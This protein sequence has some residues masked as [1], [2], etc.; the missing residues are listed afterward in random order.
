MSEIEKTH[1]FD[2]VIQI[3]GGYGKYQIISTFCMYFCC[4]VNGFIQFIAGRGL[5][6]GSFLKN[7]RGIATSPPKIV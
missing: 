4:M 7:F 1:I 3:V 6:L 5:K 2:D